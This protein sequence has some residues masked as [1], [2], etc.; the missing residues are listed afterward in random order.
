MSELKMMQLSS[1]FNKPRSSGRS[2]TGSLVQSGSLKPAM[3]PKPCV[4]KARSSRILGEIRLVESAGK[5]RVPAPRATIRM[6]VVG[7]NIFLEDA[8]AIVLM[9]VCANY[10]EG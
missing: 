3:E 8:V 6:V 9:T 7:K 1:P 10:I 2:P 4:L 5:A